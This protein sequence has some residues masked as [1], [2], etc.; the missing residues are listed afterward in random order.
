M[1]N[2]SAASIWKEIAQLSAQWQP[3]GSLS[4]SVLRG[5][6]KS[7]EASLP[8]SRSLE[9]GAGK[10]T[11]LFSQ[12]S[13]EHHVFCIDHNGLLDRIRQSEHFAAERVRFIEGPT[14]TTLPR[15]AFEGPLDLAL[16]DGPHAYPFPDLEYY[17]V[18]PHLKPGGLLIV[19][20]I[21]I[22]TVR[23]MFEILREDDMFR[24]ESVID[25]TALLRRSDSPTFD[26]LADN[27]AHQG[28]NRRHA[29]WASYLQGL[30]H[31]MPALSRWVPDR[32]KG[33]I[34]RLR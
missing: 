17:F 23:R 5:I 31:R 2:A 1:N 7:C 13:L 27:W 10:S 26:P 20:D 8:L 22:P 34:S 28:Y 3:A 16:L 18:Y 19:D 21:Q 30:V 25:N 6:V 32:V 12:L 24:V 14:Q 15:F 4:E 9:T 11:L 29:R 33:W